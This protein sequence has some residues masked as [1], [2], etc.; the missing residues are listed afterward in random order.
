MRKRGLFLRRA[1]GKFSGFCSPRNRLSSPQA[2]RRPPF[3]REEARWQRRAAPVSTT[4][5]KRLLLTT[6]GD[7]DTRQ[8]TLSVAPVQ[9]RRPLQAAATYYKARPYNIC[10][11]QLPTCAADVTN[12]APHAHRSITGRDWRREN[13]YPQQRRPRSRRGRGPRFHV[14]SGDAHR[15]RG[16]S[17]GCP[18]GGG[19]GARRGRAR[20]RAAGDAARARA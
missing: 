11:A 15:P 8:L 3:E 17:S 12:V 4:A 14:S 9:R 10:S 7:G 5:G 19:A 6:S 2:P 16:R 20:A 1:T 18:G 13:R